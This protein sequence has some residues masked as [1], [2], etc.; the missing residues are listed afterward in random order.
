V[1]LALAALS[2]YRTA[3]RLSGA[4]YVART[5]E[6]MLHAALDRLCA[7]AIAPKPRLAVS[8]DEVPEAFTVDVPPSGSVIVVTRGLLR[9]LEP[10]EI[11]AVLAHE[12]AHVLNRDGA[13]MTVASF[14]LFAAC[15][16]P[17][18]HG[19]ARPHGSPSSSSCPTRSRPSRSISCATR[20]RGTS[21]C[22][23]SSRPTAAPRS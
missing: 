3:L 19:A 6:P 20:W 17:V 12:L 11:E 23:A 9:R 2:P 16:S 13:V 7:L 15:G 18:G 14:P 10:Q 21:P 5:V 1:G 22:A 4:S 8:A